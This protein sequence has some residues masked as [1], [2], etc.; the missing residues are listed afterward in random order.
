MRDFKHYCMSN[1]IRHERPISK[2]PQ[3]NRVAERMSRTIVERVR[4]MLSHAKL[5]KSFWGEAL[6]NA[7]V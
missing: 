7:I 4:M 5:T 6:I 1:G 2:T 3:H